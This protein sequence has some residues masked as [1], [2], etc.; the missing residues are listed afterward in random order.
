MKHGCMELTRRLHA[1]YRGHP[2]ASKI[3][4]LTPALT[5]GPG[6]IAK[7]MLSGLFKADESRYLAEFAADE[8]QTHIGRTLLSMRAKYLA[9]S[10]ECT[11]A[12]F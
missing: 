11:S 4:R 9:G 12:N 2:G 10:G 7:P 6:T 1:W 3:Q 8:I 5:L